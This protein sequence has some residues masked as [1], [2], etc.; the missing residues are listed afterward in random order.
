[1]NVAVE[2]PRAP[3]TYRMPDK[4]HRAVLARKHQAQA[5]IRTAPNPGPEVW[6]HRSPRL[7]AHLLPPLGAEIQ[8]LSDAVL[9]V[10]VRLT[11][12]H[13]LLRVQISNDDQAMRRW[14]VIASS[15]QTEM[16]RITFL[17]IP[18]TSCNCPTLSILLRSSGTLI[19]MPS[20]LAALHRSDSLPAAA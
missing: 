1:M 17:P 15:E 18:L 8:Q 2:Y 4:V 5:R 3:L 19:S 11:L 9:E 10:D 16:F 20:S 14:M 13:Q 7:L 6:R 12:L